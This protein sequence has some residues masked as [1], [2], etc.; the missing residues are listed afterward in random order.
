MQNRSDVD[1]CRPTSHD[2]ALSLNLCL[3]PQEN[4]VSILKFWVIYRVSKNRHLDL[5]IG[6]I[7]INRANPD[8]L[9]IGSL[10]L[11]VIL[12]LIVHVPKGTMR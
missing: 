8:I 6:V 4:R 3:L 2:M 9:F 1:R 12:K 10:F 5:S 11:C 7:F